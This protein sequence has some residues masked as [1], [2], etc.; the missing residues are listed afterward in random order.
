V[1]FSHRRRG[2]PPRTRPTQK[3]IGRYRGTVEDLFAGTLSA[4]EIHVDISCAPSLFGVPGIITMPSKA[5]HIGGAAMQRYRSTRRPKVPPRV[6]GHRKGGTS[7]QRLTRLDRLI[8]P[9]QEP[10]ESTLD[11]VH[12]NG[13]PNLLTAARELA[14]SSH[15]SAATL[16]EAS[17]RKLTP[18]A[19]AQDG[20]FLPNNMGTDSKAA[21]R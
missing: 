13:A 4:T 19:R 12:C 3:R 16:F 14:L 1:N 15:V 9:D 2:Q 18:V 6:S 17:L 20:G 7:C 8:L 5:R 10:E 11:D 21:V